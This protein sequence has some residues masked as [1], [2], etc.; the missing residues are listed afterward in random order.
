VGE[1]ALIR[2]TISQYSPV[3]IAPFVNLTGGVTAQKFFLD[4]RDDL[5]TEKLCTVGN[6]GRKPAHIR[7]TGLQMAVSGTQD[8]RSERRDYLPLPIT[9]SIACMT[10]SL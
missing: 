8:W 5:G 9:F 6:A 4:G 2:D 7:E 3:L 10:R 1:V